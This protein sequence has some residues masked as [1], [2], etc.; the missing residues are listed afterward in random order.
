MCFVVF[1]R[2]V[3]VCVVGYNIQHSISK[4]I[5]KRMITMILIDKGIN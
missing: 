5:L 3:C 2:D 4:L 1:V